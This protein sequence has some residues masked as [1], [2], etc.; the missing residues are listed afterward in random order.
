VD[1]DR[2]L[3]LNFESGTDS[4]VRSLDSVLLAVRERAGAGDRRL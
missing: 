3:A 2:I 4:R 1:E